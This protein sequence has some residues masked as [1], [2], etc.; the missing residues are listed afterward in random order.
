M[1]L[2]TLEGLIRRRVLVNYR[3][4][5]QVARALV[6][7][8]LELDLHGGWAHAG[9]CLIRLEQIRPSCSP[10][11]L[12]IASEN[13]AHRFAVRWPAE[14]GASQT[15]VFVPR[16]DTDNLLNRIAGGRLFPGRHGRA[17]FRVEDARSGGGALAI[18]VEGEDGLAIDFRGRPTKAW[19]QSSVFEAHA[20]ASAFYARGIRG[21]SPSGAELEAVDLCIPEWRCEAFELDTL[22]S[23][24]FADQS[25][26][27]AGSV[28]LDHALFMQDIP[29]RWHAVG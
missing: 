10:V 7:E 6:P 24:Y 1:H 11:E 27:P 3:I 25:R 5:P 18:E 19:P 28:E 14:S 29:H 4:D 13:V 20:D 9:I 12:G 16:R 22:H 23:S 2:P 17:R 21:W 8:P 26:F 15:G